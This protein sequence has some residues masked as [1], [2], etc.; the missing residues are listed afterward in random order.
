MRNSSRD[1]PDD[2][3]E[4]GVKNYVV[5]LNNSGYDRKYI[6]EIADSGFKA[7]DKQMKANDDGITP[8]YRPREWMRKC[9]DSGKKKKISNWY[10]TDGFEHKLLIPST[11]HGELKSLIDKNTEA[12]NKKLK[13][14]LIEES[15]TPLLNVIQKIATVSDKVPCDDMENCLQCSSGDVGKCRISHITYKLECQEN[16]CPFYY[17][18]ETNRN[19]YSR[20]NEHMKDS[21]SQT[22]EGNEKS[23]ISNHSFLHHEGKHIQVKMKMLNRY[24]QGKIFPL[25]FPK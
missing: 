3:K 20:G 11:P 16:G 24:R 23:V 1:L 14:K 17:F 25:K 15:G 10:K 21:R 19:G 4:K 8:L 5:K 12:L 9:R 13:I 18:G 6:S 2:V 7:Y 22:I